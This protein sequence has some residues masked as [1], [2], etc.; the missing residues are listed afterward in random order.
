M[1]V[2]SYILFFI[3]IFCLWYRIAA[4]YDYGALAG[5]YVFQGKGE[6]CTLHLRAD[7]T[8]DEELSRGARVQKS[9]GLWH[10]SGEAGVEFS[11]EFVK[12][13]GEEINGQG[14]AHGYFNKSFG[15]FP[16]LTLAPEQGG[17]KFH[18]KLFH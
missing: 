16:T 13:S 5:T 1:K 11:N 8:F 12:L 2:F 6:T 9:Q 10:R 18:K 3:V 7:R 4:D 14:E 15:I 17:P